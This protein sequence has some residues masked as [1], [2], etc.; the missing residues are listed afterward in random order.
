MLGLASHAAVVPDGMWRLNM[1]HI[2]VKLACLTTKGDAQGIGI[3]GHDKLRHMGHSPSWRH[4][5][6]LLAPQA[7]Q[8][9]Q[10]AVHCSIHGRECY[11]QSLPG[12]PGFCRLIVHS[13]LGAYACL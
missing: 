6:P 1:H 10:Q 2:K 5:L 7:Q 9:Q 3:L 4:R 11:Q 12:P 13:R 8:L